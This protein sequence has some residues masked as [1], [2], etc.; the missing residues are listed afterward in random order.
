MKKFPITV[1]DNFYENPDLVRNF[2][3][4]LPYY[5]SSDGRWPGARSDRLVDV[6][7]NFYNTF[8]FKLFS[9]FFDLD[10]TNMEWDVETSFQQVVSF[11]PIRTSQLNRGWIH[12]DDDAVFSGVI[13][14][15]P[16]PKPGWG[17]SIYK[18]KPGET[19]DC[20]QKTKFLHYGESEDLDEEEH[21]KEMIFNSNK[22]VESVR[23]EN[24]YNRLILFEGG[25]YHGVPSFYSDDDE[26]R[27]TQ[28]FFVK[29]L[30]TS[31]RYPIIRSK[32]AQP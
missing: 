4:S 1:I 11:S 14:L 13:Y 18:L 5:M 27:L 17:T 12:Q 9:L 20:Q 3:L 30:I 32:L 15:N 16:D 31:S 26:P 28:V 25:E 24:V 23:V 6:N 2:A 19:D 22:F 8:T 29:K 10:S 7:V 21:E